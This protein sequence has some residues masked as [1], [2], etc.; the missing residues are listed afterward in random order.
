MN[1]LNIIYLEDNVEEA[2]IAIREFRKTMELLVKWNLE[3]EMEFGGIHIERI[4]GSQFIEERGT[5]YEFY[6]EEDISKIKKEIQKCDGEGGRTGILMDVILTKEEQDKINLDSELK[7]TFSRKLY[8]EYEKK[9][10]IYII[11]GLRNF[12]SRAWG[13]YGKEN[14]SEHYISKSLV[15]YYPSRKAMARA[16][17]WM[18]HKKMMNEKLLRKIEELELEEID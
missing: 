18:Y 9:Y 5:K 3:S 8:D 11:T 4:K 2:E 15:N 17:Y 13:I 12:G 6:N 10:G 16:L 7:I 1:K 14:L